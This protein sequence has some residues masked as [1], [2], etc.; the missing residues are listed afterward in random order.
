MNDVVT[1]QQNSTYL[2]RL[3]NSG[4]AASLK[5]R[6]VYRV[7]P[8]PNSLARGFF[9]IIDESGGDYLYPANR[10]VPVGCLRA[11]RATAHLL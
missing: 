8:D 11:M 5:A 7:I 1:K 3:K 6:K 2:F 4:Y 10:F 9:R